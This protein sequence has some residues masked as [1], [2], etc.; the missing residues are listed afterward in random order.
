M[1]SQSLTG[2]TC[3]LLLQ[4]MGEA[5]SRA[6]ELPFPGPVTGMTLLLVALRWK[7]LQQVVSSAAPGLLSHLSLLFVPVGVGVMSHL[8]IVSDFGWQIALVIVLSTWAG[9]VATL[10]VLRFG[11]ER[12]GAD[13]A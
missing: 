10:V 13:H 5:I 4:V 6:L 8:S 2:F 7:P 1:N 11:R 3:L 12:G 9:M